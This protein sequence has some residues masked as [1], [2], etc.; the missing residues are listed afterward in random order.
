MQRKYGLI[1]HRSR[2]Q[3]IRSV[4]CEEAL[5]RITIHGIGNRMIALGQNGFS[6]CKDQASSPL[7]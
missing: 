1:Q 2:Y 6:V 3:D 4:D 7:K 5:G